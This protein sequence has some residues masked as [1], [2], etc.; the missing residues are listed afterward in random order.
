MHRLPCGVKLA[1]MTPPGRDTMVL[2]DA[3]PV[4]GPA[5]FKGVFRQVL[6]S[7]SPA[8]FSKWGPTSDAICNRR[9]RATEVLDKTT[10]TPVSS[11]FAGRAEPQKIQSGR[12]LHCYSSQEHG[13][14]Q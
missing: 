5:A 7:E 11:L 14:P 13:V 10:G 3:L 2:D 8:R 1:L 4:L 9:N 6:A 12:A